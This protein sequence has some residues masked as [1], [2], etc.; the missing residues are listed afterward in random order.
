MA[1]NLINTILDALNYPRR[2]EHAVRT[3]AIGGALTLLSLLVLPAVLLTGYTVRVLGGGAVGD[4]ELPRF[5]AWGQLATD[6]LKAIAVV[7]AYV[8][9]PYALLFAA[10]FGIGEAA[11]WAAFAPIVMGGL[12]L[13]AL[14]VYAIPA[15][16]TI[17]A[18]AGRL[19][20]A[21]EVAA[22]RPILL[23]GR[24]VAGWVRAG[25]V[26]GAG[27]FLATMMNVIPVAG[28]LASVFV[29]FYVSVAAARLFGQAVG[30]TRTI[31]VVADES[32]VE[33]PVARPAD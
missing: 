18:T 24:Y 10:A 21:F 11:G 20:A 5:D 27:T 13:V 14:G 19:G 33:P 28:T 15:A 8:G 30:E 17:Y 26:L 12:A 6:G 1:Q 23:D 3:I 29:M 25:I 2:P 9:I 4:D 16:L 22:L 32:P 31:D 7:L